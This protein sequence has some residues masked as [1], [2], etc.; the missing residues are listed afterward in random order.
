MASFG[1]RAYDLALELH[2]SCEALRV[3]T[4]LRSQ[5]ERASSSIVLNLSEGSGRTGLADRR[6]FYAIAF[7]SLR[8]VQ[9]ILD[10]AAAPT[11][12]RKQAQDLGGLLYRLVY[13]RP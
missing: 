9:A 5:L 2:R 11:P 7:G 6:R 1:F 3:P 12:A 10:I 13:P 8:E 4:Y